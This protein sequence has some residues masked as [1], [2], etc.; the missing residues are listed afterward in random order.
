MQSQSWLLLVP[1]PVLWSV[2]GEVL[3]VAK[4]QIFFTEKILKSTFIPFSHMSGPIYLQDSWHFATLQCIALV[5]KSRASL[6]VG[7]LQRPTLSH[8]C[9]PPSSCLSPTVPSSWL[10][11]ARSSSSLKQLVWGVVG[12]KNI[13]EYVLGAMCL[14]HQNHS[15]PPHCQEWNLMV[16][17]GTEKGWE[18]SSGFFGCL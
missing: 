12:N 8:S 5:L 18:Q 14:L 1:G 3:R 9:C 2:P 15:Q 13:S 16:V 4:C 11:E 6:T 7:K 10:L 17:K